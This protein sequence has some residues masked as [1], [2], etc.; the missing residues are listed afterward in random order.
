MH[1]AKSSA[2]IGSFTFQTTIASQC[3][4]CI[5]LVAA[6]I[7]CLKPFLDAFN[8]GM[9]DASLK[10]HGESSNNSAGNTYALVSIGRGKKESANRSRY[11]ED[12]VEV[13]GTSAA[14]FAVTAPVKPFSEPRSTQGIHR[15]DH[16]SVSYETGERKY[17]ESIV[18]G[19]GSEVDG[20]STGH[21][22]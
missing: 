14:A 6:C 17:T 8:S 13:L 5:S 12:E 16:W 3:V 2:D 10:F 20:R 19:P 1:Q 18:D 7:P 4:L 15:T 11:M 9:L 22:L 21:S